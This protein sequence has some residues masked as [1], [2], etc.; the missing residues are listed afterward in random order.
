MLIRHYREV[1]ETNPLPGVSKRVLIGP[2][3]GAPN[4]IMRLFEVAPGAASPD[5]SHPW[6]HEIFF[7]AG[8]GVIRDDTGRETPVS[9]GYTAFLPAHEKH[10]IVNRGSTPLRFI[11]IILTGVE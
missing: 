10:C 4:F 8:E 3:E 7:L 2:Q 6:E 5:H 9:E 1:P 11:C